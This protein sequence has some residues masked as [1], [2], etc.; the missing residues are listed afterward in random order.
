MLGIGIVG[1][2]VIGRIHAR[3]IGEL[4]WVR[5]VAV[6]DPHTEAGRALAAECG[7]DALPSI[8]AILERS[9]VDV[10]IL[11]TPSGLHPVQAVA[12]A[13]AGKHIV[14]EKPMAISADGATVMID[15]ADSHGVTLAVIFQNR[16]HP[17]TLKL[18]R[19]VEAGMLGRL[20][21]G[22]AFVHWRRTADY[23]AASGGW[24]GTWELD[25]GGAL[26]N[27]SIHTIDL[28]QWMMGD[29]A[30]IA[31]HSATLSHDIEAE[32][33]ASASVR[34][35]NGALGVIQGT[36]AAS[37]DFPVRLEIVGDRGRAVLESGTL[38]HWDVPE[39]LDDS[40]L[41]DADRDAI[42]GWRADEQFGDSHRRQLRRIF[43][44]IRAG[45]EAPLPGREAR[46]PVDIILGIYE[47]AHQGRR[48]DF[49]E[50]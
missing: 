32:D 31:A 16:F 7:A 1:A 21:F 14:T 5:V 26:I 44:A 11:A 43:A 18:K 25:G 47:S 15:A 17:D 40:L 41:T 23:Y 36:T 33:A 28:L 48:I 35:R 39:P 38:S 49:I 4:D 2:G 9:D 6:A 29:V 20:I 8:D 37:G 34:F 46:K 27:Q 24:R 13:N 42:E 50:G 45:T 30:S 12:V 10:V 22:N 3:A 19:A